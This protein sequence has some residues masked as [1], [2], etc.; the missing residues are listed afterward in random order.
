MHKIRYCTSI[1]YKQIIFEFI[2]YSRF[3]VCHR[4]SWR[5]CF[6]IGLYVDGASVAETLQHWKQT[7][8]RQELVRKLN[9]AIQEL[10]N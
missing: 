4:P 6:A 2:S 8:P 3:R 9:D 10:N 5:C 7:L 1:L